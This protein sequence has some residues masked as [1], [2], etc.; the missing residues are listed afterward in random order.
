MPG[1][2]VHDL[3]QTFEQAPPPL[4][5]SLSLSLYSLLHEMVV[6]ELGHDGDGNGSRTLV[7]DLGNVLVLDAND[8][9]S[10]HLTQIVVDE[11]AIPRERR[12]RRIDLVKF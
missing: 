2:V 10:I 5:L 8:I 3:I 12:R 1:S 7:K 4:S 6:D 11:K 9:L